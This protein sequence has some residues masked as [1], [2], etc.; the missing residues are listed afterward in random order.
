MARWPID[1]P[2]GFAAVEHRVGR[3]EIAE[4]VVLAVVF[5]AHGAIGGDDALFLS[6]GEDIAVEGVGIG[7]NHLPSFVDAVV[8][9][10]DGKEVAEEIAIPEVG[11]DAFA[12]GGGQL[13]VALSGVVIAEV[14]VE[15]GHDEPGVEEAGVVAVEDA[16]G[17][18]GVNGAIV[19]GAQVVQK[20]PGIKGARAFSELVVAVPAE[21]VAADVVEA[22]FE[23]GH[24][25]GEPLVVAGGLPDHVDAFDHQVFDVGFEFQTTEPEGHPFF[26]I[27]AFGRG[28]L[29]GDAV[30]DPRPAGVHVGHWGDDFVK[31]AL[32][33]LFFQQEIGEGAE[34]LL[35]VAEALHGQ[36]VIADPVEIDADEAVAVDEHAVVEFHRAFAEAEKVRQLFGVVGGGA[37]GDVPDGDVTAWQAISHAGSRLYPQI[38]FFIR[39]WRFFNPQITQITQITTEC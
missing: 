6:E 17:V 38:S 7:E 14:A 5:V 18:I 28:H 2:A 24:G 26:V 8:D 34:V 27:A 1:V 12:E 11:H 31:E 33:V 21:R 32:V 29:R 16:H 20:V 30:F 19:A 9:G 3:F 25:L 4:V 35:G 10:V 36:D 15:F 22:F 39:R 23:F 37:V 13:F